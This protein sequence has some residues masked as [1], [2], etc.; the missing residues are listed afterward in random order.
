MI[1][2]LVLMYRLNRVLVCACKMHFKPYD[3]KV[4]AICY[5]SRLTRRSSYLLVHQNGHHTQK[6]RRVM[7]S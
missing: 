4:I 7:Q 3:L 5:S 2:L 1:R 6:C